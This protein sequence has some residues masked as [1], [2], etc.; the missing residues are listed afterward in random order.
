MS[1]R[2]NINPFPPSFPARIHLIFFASNLC[3][4]LPQ[5]S[6]DERGVNDSSLPF[7]SWVPTTSWCAIQTTYGVF[8]CGLHCSYCAESMLNNI[9]GRKDISTQEYYLALDST[10]PPFLVCRSCRIYLIPRAVGVKRSKLALLDE[11]LV[12]CH[13]V[14]ELLSRPLRS[15]SD[16]CEADDQL[17]RSKETIGK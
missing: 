10:M 4:F 11:L 13:H 3:F 6:S 9:G 15:P 14:Q 5:R 7:L 17:Y 8:K 16:V 12:L 2:E 1:P